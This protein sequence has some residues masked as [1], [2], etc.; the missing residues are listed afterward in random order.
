MYPSISVPSATRFSSVSLDEISD[1]LDRYNRCISVEE[2][3]PR[4]APR[5]EPTP[6]PVPPAV[7]PP[8]APAR[9]TLTRRMVGS[10]RERLYRVSGRVISDAGRPLGAIKLRLVV[11]GKSVARVV[12]DDRGQYSVLVK[13]SIPRGRQVY[14]Y[15]ETIDGMIYSRFLW[16]GT[17]RG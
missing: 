7:T 11:Q 3:A 9:I 15:V 12:S 13:F 10:R 2:M 8:P 16:I 6:T 1:H 5:I 17:A 4:Q 14:T